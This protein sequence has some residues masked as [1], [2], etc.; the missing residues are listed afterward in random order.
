ML[1]LLVVS[2]SGFNSPFSNIIIGI[3]QAGGIDARVTEIFK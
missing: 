1:T 2:F 3:I